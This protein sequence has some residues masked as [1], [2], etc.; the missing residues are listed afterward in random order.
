MIIRKNA[1][2]IGTLIV[3][4]DDKVGRADARL[5]TIISKTTRVLKGK[6]DSLYHY[7]DTYNKQDRTVAT[8]DWNDKD[9]V[10]AVVRSNNFAVET[11]N[12]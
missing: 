12:D 8:F 1:K 6:L 4:T 5:V 7:E 10:A 2:G 11:I 3:T 9:K